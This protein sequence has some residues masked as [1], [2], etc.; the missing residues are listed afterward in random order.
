NEAEAKRRRAELSDE[1][2][3]FGSMDGARTFVRGDALA[4]MLILAINI[5]GGFIIGV[6]QHGLSAGQAADS[7]ILLAVGDALVA[8]V[9][10]L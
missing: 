8:Q 1:A 4:G 7:Y 3:F 9:P 10:A 2:D 5:V 6:A